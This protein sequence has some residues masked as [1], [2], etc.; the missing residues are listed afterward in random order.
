VDDDQRAAAMQQFRVPA[1]LRAL[2]VE[3]ADGC[4]NGQPGVAATILREKLK[5]W[6][7]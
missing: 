3:F 4:D 5:R 2:L 1:A 6:I 7:K